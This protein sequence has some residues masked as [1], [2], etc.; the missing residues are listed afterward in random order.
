MWVMMPHREVE[1]EGA[2]QARVEVCGECMHP[3]ACVCAGKP[4]TGMGGGGY[5]E[6][7]R[8]SSEA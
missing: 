6:R 2:G 5:E 1:E 8:Q 3:R 7:S 4:C